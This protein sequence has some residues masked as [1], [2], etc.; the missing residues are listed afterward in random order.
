MKE[1]FRISGDSHVAVPGLRYPA[2]SGPSSSFV[3]LAHGAG[4]GQ[5]SPFMVK[6]ATGLATRGIDAAT[7]NFPYMERRSKVPNPAPQLE[8]CYRSAIAAIRANGWLEGRQLV[9]GGKSL[10][11]RMASH[12][13]ASGDSPH[14]IA[15]LVFLGYPLHP[16]GNPDRVRSAHLP[17]IAAPMLFVQGERDA[18]GTPAEIEP[19]LPTLRVPA[20]I[21]RVAGGDHSFTRANLDTILDGVAS[22][23]REL[24]R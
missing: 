19:L 8:A 9:I 21:H 4:A 23:I 18:F 13:A 10:G 7:F 6:A 14:P 5:E 24:P 20:T 11:G 1:A 3:L 15:G 12:V 16:P 2:A 17:A 22:W